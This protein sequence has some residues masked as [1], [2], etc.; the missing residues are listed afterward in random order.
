VDE[1]GNPTGK[2]NPNPIL[3]KREYEVEFD[4]GTVFEYA[5]NVISDNLYVQVDAEG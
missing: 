5:A 2:S 1:I 4:D 3:D